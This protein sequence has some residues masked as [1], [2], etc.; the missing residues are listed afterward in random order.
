MEY[1]LIRSEDEELFNIV[2]EAL[3]WHLSAPDKL[4]GM[5]TLQL[6]HS[7]AAA[8]PALRQTTVRMIAVATTPRFPTFLEIAFLLACDTMD[9][10]ISMMKDNMIEN[11]LYRFNPYFP[12]RQLPNY[13][14]NPQDCHD[15]NVKLGDSSANMH[16]TLSVLLVLLKTTTEFLEKNPQHRKLLPA[17][18]CYAQRCFVWAYRYECRA[19]GRSHQRI[20]MTVVAAVLLKCFGDRLPLFSS[21]LMPDIISLSVLTELPPRNDWIGTVNFSTSQQD[22]QFKKVLI[23]FVIDLLKVFPYNRFMLESRYWLMGIMYLLD[24]GLCYLRAHWSPTLF[25]DLR[26]TALQALVCT[27]PLAEHRL[28]KQYGLIRRILW[29]IEWY[30]ES[31]YE[32]PVLYWCL[33]V[34]QVSTYHRTDV[35]RVEAMTNLFDTHGIIILIHLCY[36]LLAQNEPPLEKGQAIIS[37][38]LRLLASCVSQNRRLSCCVYPGLRWPSSINNLAKEILDVVL[39]S[40]D[41]HYII[42]DRWLITTLNFIW[43]G[44]IWRRDYRELFVADDGIYKLL[45]IIAMTHPSVQCMALAMVC[46]IARAGDAVGQLVSWRANLGASNAVP[47][48]V[49]CGSTIATLLAAVFRDECRI[50]GVRLNEYGVIQDM[51]CPIMSVSVQDQLSNTE[52]SYMKSPRTPVCLAAADIPGSRMSKAFAILHLLSEDLESRVALADEAYNLY[53]NID[54]AIEDEVCFVSTFITTIIIIAI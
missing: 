11:I 39:M 3:L 16:T 35:E 12:E 49:K 47:M 52:I 2:S 1:L 4:R 18:D 36:T 10:C 8:A 54:L 30:S 25:A 38:C 44:I 51:D 32:V 17:P 40:L 7:L 53:K 41:K 46:D 29:Y 22:V 45:D 28:V 19:R 24:P 42:S 27:L 5:K 13:D 6:R 33:R 48:L 50:S 26:K 20:T 43:E 9:N 34:L 21:T 31:P 15:Y 14:I 37:L 23:Y